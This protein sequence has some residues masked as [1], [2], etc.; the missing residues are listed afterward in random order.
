MSVNDS[1]NNKYAKLLKALQRSFFKYPMIPVGVFVFTSALIFLIYFEASNRPTAEE[2]KRK[3]EI[4]RKNIYDPEDAWE[5][6][7]RR[8]QE[9]WNRKIMSETSSPSNTQ[10]S[11]NNLSGTEK[12][13]NRISATILSVACGARVGALDRNKMGETIKQ[14]LSSK[15]IDP[16]S[17][18][19]NWD[20][21]WSRA[22][23][24]DAYN[25]T[26]CLKQ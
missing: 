1:R 16:T 17:V 21:Y 12:E 4:E 9:A 13:R 22:K 19:D 15:G 11:P 25:K 6:R 24:M 5:A 26:Y 7:L 3:E 10:V 14:M 2:V 8:E 23:E 18:Y 20:Y